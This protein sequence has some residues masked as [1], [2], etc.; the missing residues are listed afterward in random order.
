MT[1]SLIGNNDYQWG[2]RSPTP[3]KLTKQRLSHYY[4]SQ[5][6]T[7]KTCLFFIKTIQ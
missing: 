1:D 7:Y 6:G 2:K 4:L 3:F 5:N